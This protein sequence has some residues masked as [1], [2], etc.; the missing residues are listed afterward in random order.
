MLYHEGV[1]VSKDN[2]ESVR[3]YRRAAEQGFALA[4]IKVSLA[5]FRGRGVAKD[6][7]KTVEW[8]HRAAAQGL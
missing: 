1:G 6:L 3:W 4:Q 7:N 2:A 5:Y 8:L